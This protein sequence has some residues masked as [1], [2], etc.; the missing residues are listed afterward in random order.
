MLP[1]RDSTVLPPARWPELDCVRLM[2]AGILRLVYGR[3]SYT[4]DTHGAKPGPTELSVKDEETV[5]IPVWAGVGAIVIGGA[6][7]LSGGEN[8][9]PRLPRT[10]PV[11]P[12]GAS[13]PI[14][15]P[16]VVEPTF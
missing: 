13:R 12:H 3:F 7:C 16:A 5:T 2:A 15:T 4:K 8:G 1:R 6:F 9:S 11:D 14:D 10:P